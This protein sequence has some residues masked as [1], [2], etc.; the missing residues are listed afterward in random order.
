[1]V[2]KLEP[3]TAAYTGN[4]STPSLFLFPKLPFSIQCIGLSKIKERSQ[5]P[6]SVTLGNK[7]PELDPYRKTSHIIG[8]IRNRSI[9][10]TKLW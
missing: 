6:T 1:M 10:K 8:I 4:K 3:V 9:G 5:D 2:V 7:H